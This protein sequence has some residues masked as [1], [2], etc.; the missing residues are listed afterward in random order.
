MKDLIT[1]KI[2]QHML[3][4]EAKELSIL[5][6]LKGEIERSEQDPKKGKI[7]LDDSKIYAI[8]HKLIESSDDYEKTILEELLPKQLTTDEIDTIIK[9]VV[10]NNNLS[11]NGMRG[12]GIIVKHFNEKY[13]GRFESKYITT[14]G[15]EFL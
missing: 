1:N 8:I 15:K 11:G 4:K 2:K 9:E 5:R 14:K 7:E 13:S 6:V 3:N 12:M 10:V